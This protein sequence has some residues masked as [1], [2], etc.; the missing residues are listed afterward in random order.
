MG[1][2]QFMKG[3]SWLL[4]LNLLIKPIW[5]FAIDR[6]VQNVVGH[7]V[8]GTYFAL[9]NLCY[10][11]LFIADAGLTNMLTQKLAAGQALNV[12]QL[13]WLKLAMVL[14]Y[15]FACGSV[16]LLTGVAQWQILC[17][18]I[19]VHSLTS[20]FLFLRGLL[21]ARQQFR[22]DALFSVLDK[23][24][25]IILCAGPLYGLFRPMT[26]ELFLQLQTVSGSVAVASLLLLLVRKKSLAKG[27]R[28]G[29]KTLAA[30][31]APFV[32]IFLLM[33]AHNR[34]D[35]FL[36]E[37]LHPDGATQAGIYAMSYRL[38][39][40]GNVAGYLTASF[41]VPFLARHQ[42][43]QLVLQRMIFVARHGLLLLA[44]GVVAFVM[45]FSPW[46]AQMLYGAG[47]AY[48]SRV[49]QLC[50]LSLPGCYLI[51]VYGS[52]LTATARFRPF[53]RVLL[54]AVILNL[55]LNLLLIPK[56][57][58]IGCCLAAL[59][60][61][62]FCGFLLWATVTRRLAISPAVK[63]ALLY[64]AVA[65]LCGFCF[66]LGQKL[67][68]NVWIIFSSIALIAMAAAAWQRNA[69]RKVF[70]SLSK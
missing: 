32:T 31:T 63:A 50:L 55:G 61:Q 33:S 45:V 5:I 65:L 8:Y 25:L 9:H 57:G 15:A 53:I 34:L 16:A 13:L 62:Y 59:V 58:A 41:L 12:R 20:F 28:A 52:A 51:H 2:S 38:L 11:L 17:F 68:Q 27:Q 3:L 56:Y 64:P 18:V 24:L 69:I 67:T 4:V 44:A 30:W 21:A 23:T 54:V 46:L 7:E 1:A 70:L 42:H 49:M 14:L 10:V 43:H 48:S 26:I 37:R 47:D 29:L 66:W 39:D 40:A 6:Q 22:A 35:A 60:S 19:A 36:L